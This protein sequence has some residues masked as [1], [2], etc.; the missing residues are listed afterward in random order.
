MGVKKLFYLLANLDL[1]IHTYVLV[2]WNTLNL[3]F[4]YSRAFTF[5]LTSK[6]NYVQ[7]TGLEAQ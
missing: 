4:Y 6:I 2:T 5:E 1:H 3:D 7:S